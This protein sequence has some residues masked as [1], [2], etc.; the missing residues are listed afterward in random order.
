MTKQ[1]PKLQHTTNY[2]LFEVSAFNRDLHNLTVITASMK[3]H[4]FIPVYAL[5]CVKAESGKLAIKAG[6]H[7]LEA[8][9]KL[10]IGV[11]YIVC[12]DS[13]SIAELEKATNKWTTGDFLISHVRSGSASHIALK[14]FVDR[15]GI[16][17]TQAC[18]LFSGE[19]ASSNN[20][21]G[22]LKDGTF[23]IKDT[24]RAEAIASVI[25]RLKS[26]GI[27]FAT[28]RNL[29]AAICSFMWLEQFNAD[30][31]IQKAANN[32]NLFKKCTTVIQYQEMIDYLYNYGAKQKMALAFLAREHARKRIPM[33]RKEAAE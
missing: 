30:V 8:A 14:E 31:L 25:L 20:Q 5:H 29:V 7:R 33:N 19:S 16:S 23:Q 6:H 2:D 15:T 32:L 28:Q 21:S 17:I 12:E 3:K 27:D 18:S 4:G 1:Q 26:I 22:C 10:G 13:A 9:R 11:Y 24:K